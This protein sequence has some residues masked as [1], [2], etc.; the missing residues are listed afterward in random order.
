MDVS[1]VPAVEAPARG[2]GASRGMF[3]LGWRRASAVARSDFFPGADPRL[4]FRSAAPSEVREGANRDYLL[5]GHGT[6]TPF[7]RHHSL[8]IWYRL[9]PSTCDSDHHST[10][11]RL[12]LMTT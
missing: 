5:G 12:E 6:R 4:C 1:E 10:M 2:S 11:I 8:A 7:R 3:T 9:L